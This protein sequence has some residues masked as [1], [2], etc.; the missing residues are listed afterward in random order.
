ML[1][2]ERQKGSWQVDEQSCQIEDGKFNI[3]KIPGERGTNQRT[4]SLTPLKR[5]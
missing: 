1:D 4:T 5:I 2:S 3:D